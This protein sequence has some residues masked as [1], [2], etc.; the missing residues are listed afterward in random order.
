MGI[1]HNISLFSGNL[2]I[3]RLPGFVTTKRLKPVLGFE[4]ACKFKGLIFPPG[5][6]MVYADT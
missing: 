2:S 3:A 5:F 4:F 1:V 6:G